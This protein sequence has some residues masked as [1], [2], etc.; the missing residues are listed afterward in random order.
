MH[1]PVHAVHRDVRQAV[2]GLVCQ[3]CTAEVGGNIGNGLEHHAHVFMHHHLATLADDETES[4]GC[5][6]YRRHVGCHTVHEHI[7]RR[8]RL[9]RA[10]IF[11]RASKGDHKFFGRGIHIGLGQGDAGGC[12]GLLVPG[13]TSWTVTRGQVLLLGED[14]SFVGKDYIGR[15]HS[16]G[17]LGLLQSLHRGSAMSAV[18]AM[19]RTTCWRAEP[20]RPT[21]ST[22]GRTR[23]VVSTFR[24]CSACRLVTSILVTVRMISPAKVSQPTTKIMRLRRLEN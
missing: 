23:A 20:H 6:A 11:N 18:A 12:R 8:H 4:V 2:L 10:T 17:N 19:L 22:W 7:Q 14:H 21:L 1:Q 13:P 3:A 15:V 16:T 5:W 24:A 9:D